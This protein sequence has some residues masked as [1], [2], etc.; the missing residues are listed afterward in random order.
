MTNQPPT[1]RPQPETVLD[2]MIGGY[3][4]SQLIYVAAK[5]GI[6]DCLQAGP[7]GAEQLAAEVGAQPE[8]LYRLL[9]ALAV[10]GVFAET[11]ARTF[12]L[13][14][15]GAL[16]QTTAPQSLR[17][18]A[19]LQGEELYRTW[20]ELLNSVRTGQPGFDRVYGMSW[21][22]Y[23]DEHPQTAAA[24]N[25]RMTAFFTQRNT[26]VAAAYDFSS[27]RTIID[28]AGGQG[29]LLATILSAY[30]TVRGVLFDLPTVVE[31]APPL[32]EQAGV[33]ERCEVVGGDMFVAVPGGGDVYLLATIIHDWK[34]EQAVAILRNCRRATSDQARLLLVEVVVPSDTTPSPTKIMDVGMMVMMHGK[35]RTAAE[36]RELYQAAGFALTQVIPTVSP[37]CIL[38]GRPV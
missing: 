8:S 11:E 2:F 3:T 5:L 19:I 14:R 36:Y 38:E 32:L 4:T 24:F 30:P 34:Y 1:G 9:R 15:M 22:D 28:V 16:L 37:Y 6:A 10:M 7:K 29:S 12:A 21:W 23:L 13:T 20:G 17:S 27:C 33:R 18:H 35:E 31:A 26:G 25:Q